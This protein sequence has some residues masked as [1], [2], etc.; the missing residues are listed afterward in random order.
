MKTY[1]NLITE[2]KFINRHKASKRFDRKFNEIEDKYPGVNDFFKVSSEWAEYIKPQKNRGLYRL[3][4][5]MK[6]KRNI[7]DLSDSDLRRVY[8]FLRQE[9]LDDYDDMESMFINAM[10]S[11]DE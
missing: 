9:G 10:E 11:E 7:E 8:T 5:K 1:E 4:L 3:L 6:G 2:F